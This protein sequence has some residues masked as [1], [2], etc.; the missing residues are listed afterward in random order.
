MWHVAFFSDDFEAFD[1]FD[2]A[3]YVVEEDWTVFL[4][5]GIVRI[6]RM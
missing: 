5:P 3:D 1:G 2:V 6:R 4:D